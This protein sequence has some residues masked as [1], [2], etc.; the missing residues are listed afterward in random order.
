MVKASHEIGCHGFCESRLRP[1]NEFVPYACASAPTSCCAQYT[2]ILKQFAGAALESI[3]RS[4][5]YG[6]AYFRFD[7]R[8]RERER[9]RKGERPGAEESNCRNERGATSLC[10]WLQLGRRCAMSCVCVCVCVC[11][12]S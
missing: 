11:V 9:E 4:T 2:T 7:H 10:K 1:G 6:D 3:G 12:R 8:E 5:F